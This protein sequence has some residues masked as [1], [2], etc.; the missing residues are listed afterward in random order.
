MTTGGTFYITPPPV[1]ISLRSSYIPQMIISRSL[2]DQVVNV[3]VSGLSDAVHSIFSL[4]ENLQEK[5]PFLSYRVLERER[6]TDFQRSCYPT[7]HPR[8]PEELSKDHQVSRVQGETHVGRSDGQHS[9]AGV[10][11]GL[12]PVAELLALGRGGGA[13]HTYV[14][15]ALWRTPPPH[16]HTL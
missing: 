10:S 14:V 8:V 15:D 4:N 7:S 11:P 12:E 2:G 16:R 3:D 9:H 5:S 1:T 13:I 6:T